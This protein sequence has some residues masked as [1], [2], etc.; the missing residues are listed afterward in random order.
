MRYS[1]IVSLAAA[2]TFSAVVQ[3]SDVLDLTKATFEDVANADLS[4]YVRL[5]ASSARC[6]VSR[7]HKMIHSSKSI[8]S[9]S[10]LRGKL[11]RFEINKMT[12]CQNILAS[13]SV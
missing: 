5:P 2:L 7:E 4:L 6:F 9:S 11:N 8:E 12:T 13:S 1:T 10:S 3:A